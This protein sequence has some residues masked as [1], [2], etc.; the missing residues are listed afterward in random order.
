M[1]K[2]GYHKEKTVLIEAL[3]KTLYNYFRRFYRGHLLYLKMHLEVLNSGEIKIINLISNVSSPN[4]QKEYKLY[5]IEIFKYILPPKSYIVIIK[6]GSAH[7]RIDSNKI[8]SKTI[9]NIFKELLPT[10]K[11]K[12]LKYKTIYELTNDITY[13]INFSNLHQHLQ[14]ILNVNKESEEIIISSNDMLGI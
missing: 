6:N 4:I 9:I 5:F 2:L 14:K 12:K 8:S 10:V 1:V 3:V 13:N 11:V 7:I